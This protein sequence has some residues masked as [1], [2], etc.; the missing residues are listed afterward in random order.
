MEPISEELVEETWQEVALFSAARAGKEM[1]KVGK[2]QADLLA[3]IF[4]LTE[5]LDQ[6]VKELALYMFFVIYQ[7]FQKGYGKKIKRITADQIIECY[8]DNEKLV[9]SLETAHDRFYDRIARVQVSAQ[10]YVL[11][12]VVDTLF[13]APEDEDPVYL[14]E[15]DTGFLFLLLKTVI[16]LLNKETET[17]A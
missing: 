10:P 3:F 15:E 11:K 1:T 6:Q 2:N 4:E 13:E 8:E 9:E 12:Y 16:D 5:D 7:T 17:F 14:T